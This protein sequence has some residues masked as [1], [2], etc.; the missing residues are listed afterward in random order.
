VESV[1]ASQ[2]CVGEGFYV[3]DAD[4]TIDQQ[5]SSQTFEL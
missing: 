2:H 5:L 3:L 4:A 1:G